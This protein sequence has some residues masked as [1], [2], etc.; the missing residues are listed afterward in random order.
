MAKSP[1]S[2]ADKVKKLFDEKGTLTVQEMFA[3]FLNDTDIDL[4][5]TTLRHRIRSAVWGLKKSGGIIAMG[6]GKYKKI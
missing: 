6:D 4:P 5:D 3:H 2:F 1:G